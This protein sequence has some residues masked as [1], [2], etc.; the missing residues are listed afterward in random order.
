MHVG[1]RTLVTFA[2][3]LLTNASS[4]MSISI[5]FLHGRH[6]QAARLLQDRLFPVVNNRHRH[7]FDHLNCVDVCI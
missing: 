2:S 3:E 5:A 7:T 6:A 4:S 1:L